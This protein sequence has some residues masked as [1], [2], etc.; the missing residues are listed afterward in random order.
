VFQYGQS[1]ASDVSAPCQS[2]VRYNINVATQFE[3]EA[4]LA[5][6]K[7]RTLALEADMINFPLCVNQLQHSRSFYV[8]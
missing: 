7:Q 5:I 8:S 4:F 6:V 3:T 2:T 1:C